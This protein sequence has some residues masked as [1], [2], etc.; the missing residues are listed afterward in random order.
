MAS[1]SGGALQEISDSEKGSDQG[2]ALNKDLQEFTPK[3]TIAPNNPFSPSLPMAAG[4]AVGTPVFPRRPTSPEYELEKAKLISR[5]EQ[6]DHEHGHVG[7]YDDVGVLTKST[8]ARPTPTHSK[9][10][11]DDRR[12]ER[13]LKP[14][15]T[16][17]TYLPDFPLPMTEIDVV[18][19]LKSIDTGY[20]KI[21]RVI[22]ANGMPD[23]TTTGSHVIKMDYL[24]YRTTKI[25]FIFTTA[26]LWGEFCA[27]INID[28]GGRVWL[29]GSDPEVETLEAAIFAIMIRLFSQNPANR[30]LESELSQTQTTPAGLLMFMDTRFGYISNE[31]EFQNI[32]FKIVNKAFTD[33][34]DLKK[35]LS[36]LRR[37]STVFNRVHPKLRLEM[38]VADINDA[39]LMRG[40]IEGLPTDLKIQI[41][42]KMSP[43][44]P[45]CID[46]LVKLEAVLDSMWPDIIEARNYASETFG[47]EM[48]LYQKAHGNDGQGSSS[49][50]GVTAF[51]GTTKRNMDHITCHGCGEKGHYVKDCPKPKKMDGQNR[52]DTSSRYQNRN[53]GG[54]GDRGGYGNSN[55]RTQISTS[56]MSEAQLR[57]NYRGPPELFDP[58]FVPKGR[59]QYSGGRGG[60]S[61][62]GNRNGQ[63]NTGRPQQR[64]ALTQAPHTAAAAVCQWEGCGSTLHTQKDCP[65]ARAYY[66]AQPQ[67]ISYPAS[68]ESA[69]VAMSIIPPAP[70]RPETAMF[71]FGGPRAL[72]AITNDLAEYTV[73]IDSSNKIIVTSTSKA[74][75]EMLYLPHDF[76]KPS[77]PIEFDDNEFVLER[78]NPV[79]RMVDDVPM[80]FKYICGTLYQSWDLK[81]IDFFSSLNSVQGP[82]QMFHLGPLP[83]WTSDTLIDLAR[84]AFCFGVT[85]AQR[86]LKTLKAI[87]RRE[88]VLQ[89]YKSCTLPSKGSDKMLG[90]E[91]DIMAQ[92]RNWAP[93]EYIDTMAIATRKIPKGGLIKYIVTKLNCAGPTLSI[94]IA[95]FLIALKSEERCP[96]Q[97][98]YCNGI[99]WES[100]IYGKQFPGDESFLAY[101]A[102]DESY[103]PIKKDEVLGQDNNLCDSRLIYF[104]QIVYDD[105]E[106]YDTKTA[107]TGSVSE[108]SPLKESP[109]YDQGV[110]SPEPIKCAF[111]KPARYASGPRKVPGLA[112]RVKEAKSD[113]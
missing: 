112:W 55:P 36:S 52:N 45:E 19:S 33:K 81:Y 61:N 102:E 86:A 89:L 29:N 95:A 41:N 110:I 113:L 34:N 14:D 1:S 11:Y 90:L 53:S 97:V 25:K 83:S 60:Y 17:F 111:V 103:L 100:D 16:N 88:E 69:R 15:F 67:T 96:I 21:E 30:D 43:T 37:E 32:R 9:Y 98:I 13:F 106:M 76:V 70:P 58:H 20:K 54:G 22:I 3:V 63:T 109:I 38:H 4:G 108:T 105:F 75:A 87:D 8:S 79:K 59:D 28:K 94:G 51:M 42:A 18:V 71:M 104:K 48:I 93:L 68:S 57:T 7:D 77:Y 62:I 46:S 74:I 72:M 49:S 85:C 40:V 35:Y 39:E 44:S 66:T 73:I 5:L 6:L 82:G 10:N 27:V 107:I 47:R 64:L 78:I 23:I 91:E 31:R 56:L 12:P 80:E 26:Q 65:V 92:I 24:D 2:G 101:C 84:D 99:T 50:G